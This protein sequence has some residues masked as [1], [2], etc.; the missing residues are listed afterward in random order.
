MVPLVI[1]KTLLGLSDDDLFD[2]C[3]ANDQ[4][5]IER[6]ADGSL[7]IMSPSGSKAGH[8]ALRF[9]SALS[10]GVNRLVSATHSIALPVLFCPIIPC[11][12]QT[13]RG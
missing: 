8:R 9:A 3:S 12:R 5:L 4:L 11:D 13:P 2:L 1:P 10:F 7:T 6:N